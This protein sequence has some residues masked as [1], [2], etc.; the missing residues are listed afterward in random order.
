ML[1]LN[2]LH[3]ADDD[4]VTDAGWVDAG[5]VT[6]PE[7]VRR[8]PGDWDAGGASRASNWS[9]TGGERKIYSG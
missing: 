3:H 1:R 9:P 4:D 6:R 8:L 7:R 5:H 2:N